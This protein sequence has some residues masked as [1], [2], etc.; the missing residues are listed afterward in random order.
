MSV[1]FI[2]RLFLL[3]SALWLASCVTDGPEVPGAE[4]DYK[5]AAKL[6]AQLGVDYM[7][8][9]KYDIAQIKL[10]KAI[11]QDPR[12]SQAWAALGVLYA[13][14]DEIDKAEHA[15]RRALDLGDSDPYVQ[16]NFGVFLCG[17]YYEAKGKDPRDISEALR[18]FENAATNIKYTTP[19][20]AW[21]NAGVCARHIPDLDKAEGYFRK[22]L[23]RSPDFPDALAQ[24]AWLSLQRQDY[25]RARAFLQRYERVGPPTPETLLI[26][27]KTEAAL[28]DAVGARDYMTRLRSKFPE[29]EEN[30]QKIEIQ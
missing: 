23:Q 30:R 22:A 20:A 9:G 1:K 7:R 11:D 3:C 15:Y 6:N 25:I 18:F 29:A 8:R 10:E 19:Q 27:A 21:T 24:M 12:Q 5:E 16:N 17:K 13:Q 2:S 4:P 26:G 28:G 14:M